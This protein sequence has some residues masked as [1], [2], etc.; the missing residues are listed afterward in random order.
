MGKL[1][2]IALAKQSKAVEYRGEPSIA[3]TNLHYTLPN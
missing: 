2:T 3:E 1:L